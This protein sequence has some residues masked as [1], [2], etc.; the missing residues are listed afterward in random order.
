MFCGECVSQGLFKREKILLLKNSIDVVVDFKSVLDSCERLH[1]VG[2]RR[3]E[4]I[5]E[6]CEFRNFLD[7]VGGFA[8]L[9]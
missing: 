8:Y 9:R 3:T 6:I 1:A 4:D 5:I 2:D 7:G